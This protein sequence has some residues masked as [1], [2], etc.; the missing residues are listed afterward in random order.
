VHEL[1]RNQPKTKKELLDITTWRAP[2]E[3]AVRAI[4][5]Q[6]D[7]KAVPGG[8]RGVKGAKRSAKGNKRG[9]KW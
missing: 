3:E 9:P 8:S 1:S 5:I 6:G 4:F 2:G 7:V